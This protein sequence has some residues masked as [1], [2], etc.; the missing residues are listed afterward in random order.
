MCGCVDENEV[1]LGIENWEL[2]SLSLS[3]SFHLSAKLVWS[4]ARNKEMSNQT[5]S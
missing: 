5:S 3:L 2:V 1:E 4:A